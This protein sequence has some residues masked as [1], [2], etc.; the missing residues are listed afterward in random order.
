MDDVKNTSFRNVLAEHGQRYTRQR[1]VIF[2]IVSK[3][4]DHPTAEEI[5][6]EARTLLPSISLATIYKNLDALISCGLAKKVNHTDGSRRYCCRADPHHHA[7]CLSCGAVTD[8]PGT[9]GDTELSRVRNEAGDFEI[10]GY[11]LEL[12]GYCP[13]CKPHSSS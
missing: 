2:S 12:N 10:V 7:T 6:L 8:I 13:K 9:L 1:D 5:F 3:T 4:S 11:E